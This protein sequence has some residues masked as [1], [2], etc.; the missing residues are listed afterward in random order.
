MKIR[1]LT[2]LAVSLT[3]IGVVAF[4]PILAPASVTETGSVPWDPFT[5]LLGTDNLGRDVW[6]R[7]LAGGVGFLPALPLGIATTLVAAVVALIACQSPRLGAVLAQTSA[8]LLAV[9]SAVVVLSAAVLLPSWAAVG[10]VMTVLGIPLSARQLHAAAEPLASSGFVEA[11]RLRGESRLLVAVRELA[12]ALSPVVVA[13]MGIRCVAA[14]H[15]LVGVHVL[16]LGPQAPSPDWALMIRDNISGVLLSPVATL[17]PAI[18]LSFLSLALL[19][20][21][22]AAAELLR[23]PEPH[24]QRGWSDATTTGTDTEASVHLCDVEVRRAGRIVIRVPRFVVRPGEVVGIQGPSGVGKSTLLGVLAGDPAPGLHVSGEISLGGRGLVEAGRRCWRRTSIGLAEQDPGDTIDARLTVRQVIADGRPESAT[25]PIDA[26]LLDRAGLPANLLDRPAR[27][28]GGQAARVSMLRAL[29]SD[30]E[31]LLL[32]EP[33]AGLESG[34]IAAV[35]RLV[36]ERAETLSGATVVVS[37]DEAFLAAVCDRVEHVVPGAEGGTVT[38]DPAEGEDITDLSLATPTESGLL[39]VD[40]LDVATPDGRL[41]LEDVTF[42]VAA[43]EM[44]AVQGPSGLGKSTLLRTICGLHP[45]RAGTPT[46]PSEVIAPEEIGLVAQDA[47]LA[48]N[49]FWSIGRQVARAGA[50]SSSRTGAGSTQPL[51]DLSVVELAGRR[52]GECSGGQRQRANLARSLAGEPELLLVD[53]PTAGLDARAARTVLE[54]LAEQARRGRAVVIVTHDPDVA[55]ACHRV[56][57][58]ERFS[59][60]SG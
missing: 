43:G 17:A 55:S 54:I 47:G 60:S 23:P 50:G 53:E 12:P 6:S 2:T 57:H 9:P 52:P 34:S 49:P 51:A 33:T 21:L 32:D 30:P 35:T 10:L 31:V 4:G 36:R 25:G 41:L 7:L 1:V 5:G 37:H 58:V 42:E 59:P 24:A 26:T 13:D 38:D 14:M 39:R 27:L 20:G 29:C 46:P 11:A 15:L 44:L 48:L 3:L 8:S 22:D 40:G 19:A 16:G 56:L 45:M 18:A 28:S